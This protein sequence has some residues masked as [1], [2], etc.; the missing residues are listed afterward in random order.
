MLRPT[1]ALFAATMTLA[2]APV[3]A[4]DVIAS[5]GAY[6]GSDDLHNSSGRRL[7]EAWQVLRQDRANFHR[8]GISQPGDEWDPIFDD[9]QA[10]AALESM[11][12]QGYISSGARALILGGDASVYVTIWGDGMNATYVEVVT[13]EECGC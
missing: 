9:M 1:I 10:R 2:A 6:I 7:T 4:E 11:S 3:S 13:Y 5:Y 12:R 8:F